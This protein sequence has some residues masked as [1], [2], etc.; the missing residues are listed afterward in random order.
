MNLR[1]PQI[2]FFIGPSMRPAEV[3]AEFDGLTA[4]VHILPPIQ[5]G[6]VLRLMHDL[7]DV[8][9]IIDGNFLQAPAVLHKEILLALERGTRVLGAASL[10][11]LRAAELD[12]YGMEGVGTIYGWYRDGIIDGDD[13][14]A[15][16]HTLADDGFRQLT[17]PLVNIRHHV[18][19]AR[20]AGVLSARTGAVIIGSA[21][22]LCFSERTYERVLKDARRR[23]AAASELAAFRQFVRR[24]GVDL[25]HADALALVRT[26]AARVRG[27]EPWP[28]PLPLAVPRTKHVRIHE[29]DYAGHS[30]RG[31]H[32]PDAAALALCQL[33]D[34]SFPELF[35]RVALRSL[36]VDEARERGL[37]VDRAEVLRDRF[38]REHG[39]ASDPAYRA[40]LDAH[41]LS[42]PDLSTVLR[43]I[44][45]EERLLALYRAEYGD[46]DARAAARLLADVGNRTGMS[47]AELTEPFWMRPGVLWEEPLIRA[48]K[49]EG[50]FGPALDR[51]ARILALD[52]LLLDADP[53][54]RVTF[55]ALIDLAADELEAW[56]ARRWRVE[57][58]DLEPALR[59]R[60][61]VRYRDFLRTAR[62]AFVY[63]THS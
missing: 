15:V 4:D 10:G 38:R 5:Q 22:R 24:H 19:Q 37:A 48:L 25:K 20:E 16:L 49:F 46:E 52:A 35:R 60:G 32:V 29:R 1:P 39:L 2:A 14:V 30:A 40:W 18:Q 7:P 21:K 42:E 12:L 23:I 53:E 47:A 33:L 34:E 59:R 31:R 36:A 27:D 11:A 13:E 58:A 8:L 61:F 44:E 50:Q 17:E 43:D 63:E 57:I 26:V 3:R 55:D 6:D 56:A 9:A 45:L 41:Y 62:L 54:L 28:A 51:A